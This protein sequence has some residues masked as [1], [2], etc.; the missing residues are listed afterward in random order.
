MFK[1]RYLQGNINAAGFSTHTR[2]V[3]TWVNPKSEYTLTRL[4]VDEGGRYVIS[5][6]KGKNMEFITVN[7]YGPNFDCPEFYSAPANTAHKF[8]MAPKIWGGTSTWSEIQN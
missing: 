1:D 8:D 5:K 2:G 4:A 6:I 7:V 3:L